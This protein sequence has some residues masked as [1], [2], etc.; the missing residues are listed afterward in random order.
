MVCGK[1]DIIFAINNRRYMSYNF[2]FGVTDGIG[3]N[4]NKGVM[5]HNVA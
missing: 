4:P 1:N 2:S 3:T 5:L